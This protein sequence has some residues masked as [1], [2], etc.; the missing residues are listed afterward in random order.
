MP[1][2]AARH[3]AAVHGGASDTVLG[4]L[5]VRQLTVADINGMMLP[6]PIART[7]EDN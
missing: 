1:R 2:T 4:F 3:T 6:V 5:I 7:N